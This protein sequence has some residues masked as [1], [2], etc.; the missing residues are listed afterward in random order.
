MKL[1]RDELQDIVERTELSPEW[2]ELLN[3]VFKELSA[4]NEKVWNETRASVLREDSNLRVAW[5]RDWDVVTA[6]VPRE[7]DYDVRGVHSVLHTH[8]EWSI[9]DDVLGDSLHIDIKRVYFLDCPHVEAEALFAHERDSDY[10]YEGKI[11]VQGKET[12]F[13]YRLVPYMCFIERERELFD[14]AELYGIAKPVLFSP[15]ARRAAKIQVSREDAAIADLLQ[16]A[17]IA[18][19]C[20]AENH[21]A[22][23][24]KSDVVLK[25]N[26][27]REK[28]KPPPYHL[29]EGKNRSFFAPYGD[30]PIYRYEFGN[31]NEREFICPPQVEQKH[32]I[33]A[34]KDAENRCVTL[35]TK[36]PLSEDCISMQI[37]GDVDALEKY[38]AEDWGRTLFSNMDRERRAFVFSKERLRTR[39]DLERVLYALQMPD[40]GLNCTIREVS[41]TPKRDWSILRPYAK[42]F[43]YGVTD[44]R[45]EQQLYQINRNLPYVY[46]LF[47]GDAAFLNDY[48]DFVLSFLK[49]RYP[50]FQWVGVQ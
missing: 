10:P 45:R 25:W 29:E 16:D 37:I 18:P 24:I 17:G 49:Q 30:R 41:P 1:K 39:G 40:H 33:S 48:A 5:S 22:D 43:S 20:F 38:R 12:P 4:R 6:L 2:K 14:M 19:F 28:R 13:R 42:Q 7:K 3:T 27:H 9:D 23:K 8:E 47:S 35:I 32:L 15:Y 26:I 34:V 36:H 21:L 11:K 31:V 44:V 50:D 46:I